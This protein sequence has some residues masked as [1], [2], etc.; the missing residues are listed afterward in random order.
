MPEGGHPTDNTW[1]RPHSAHHPRTLPSGEKP[2]TTRPKSAMVV[3]PNEA[4]QPK[5]GSGLS[6]MELQE[7]SKSVRSSSTE[8]A[9]QTGGELLIDYDPVGRLHDDPISSHGN[10]LSTKLILF[11]MFCLVTWPF[12]NNYCNDLQW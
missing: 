4:N 6:W 3:A 7:D 8:V 9:T 2:G 11:L 10:I 12:T 1:V 5:S